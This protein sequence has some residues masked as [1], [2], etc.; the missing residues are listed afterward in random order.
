MK[1]LIRYKLFEK[2]NVFNKPYI[3]FINEDAELKVNKK[4]A[5]LNT[6]MTKLGFNE[7]NAK[8]LDEKCGALS[9]WMG[10]KIKNLYLSQKNP[11]KDM[12]NFTLEAKFGYEINYIM[13]WIRVGLN[14]T[15]G[16][17]KELSLK[18]LE[19]KAKEW[20]DNLK[21]G[22]GDINYIEE[23]E[24]LID[25]RDAEGIG[26][27]WANLNTNEDTEEGERMGHCARTS[28]CNTLYS[29]RNTIKLNDKY[30]LNKSVLTASIS[31]DNKICQLKN[32]GNGKPDDNYHDYIIDLLLNDIVKQVGGDS[33]YRTSKDFSL[34]DLDISQ[35]KYLY[36]KKP[37]L[38]ETYSNKLLL[39]KHKIITKDS[40]DTSFI[41]KIDVDEIDKYVDGGYTYGEK[42][43]ANGYKT[44][45]DIFEAILSGDFMLDYYANNNDWK[46]PLKYYVNDENENKLR[47]LINKKALEEKIDIEELDLEDAIIELDYD[48]I[49]DVLRF[50]MDDAE[51]DAYYEHMYKTLKDCLEEYGN[52]VE[53]SDEGVVIEADFYNITSNVEPSDID[54]TI[55]NLGSSNFSEIL[56][57]LC[58]EEGLI[59]KPKFEISDYYTPDIKK[60]IF[61][62]ILND[63]ILE[64]K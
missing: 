18:D 30:T 16:E 59:E 54:N 26:F 22:E 37:I 2:N 62:D 8:F 52:V 56:G 14:G 21:I 48:D 61:N 46:T 38:F 34:Q 3:T 5:K 11:I 40:I 29:L 39:V 15:L 45:V 35:I 49:K 41:L 63:K 55:D 23:H 17:Y 1:F 27:Y 4:L 19:I 60:E 44:K 47:E 28:R 7:E 42:K 20:H 57:E 53:I 43:N 32:A 36:E 6:L 25:F 51:S 58:R 12:N 13:D 64:I 31:D 50:T 9:V 10:N 24:I 33:E